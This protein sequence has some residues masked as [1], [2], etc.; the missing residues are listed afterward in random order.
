MIRT[1]MSHHNVPFNI[2]VDESQSYRPRTPI[3]LKIISMCKK[4]CGAWT[5]MLRNN[6]T[7]RGIIVRETNILFRKIGTHINAGTVTIL[8]ASTP[9]TLTVSD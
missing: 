8:A 3:I 5:K 6:M 1:L 9:N 7:R 4:G 2:R